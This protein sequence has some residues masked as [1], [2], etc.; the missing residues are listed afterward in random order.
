M[1]ISFD[2]WETLYRHTGTKEFRMQTVNSCIEDFCKINN[3]EFTNK[4]TD[5]FRIADKFIKQQHAS[6]IFPSD[7]EIG[8]FLSSKMEDIPPIL[9]VQLKQDI[10]RLYINKNKPDLIDGAKD[11]FMKNQNTHKFCISSDTFFIRGKTI[12]EIL[13]SDNMLNFFDTFYFSD[14]MGQDKSNHSAIE[15][16]IKKFNL[17][18]EN[19][20][21]IGDLQETDG[22]YA[23]NCN[24]NFIHFLTSEKATTEER[25]FFKNYDELEELINMVQYDC[26]R[27][28]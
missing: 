1:L 7:K 23:K 24:I 22:V 17:K 12:K 8:E 11:F 9:C 16:L 28:A 18:H 27:S 21:H 13:N 20:I 4:V 6:A 19:V 3:I 15:G 10:E 26:N 5:F 2:F 14:E 25:Y